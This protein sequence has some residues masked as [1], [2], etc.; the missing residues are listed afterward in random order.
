M[1]IIIFFKKRMAVCKLYSWWENEVISSDD[2]VIAEVRMCVGLNSKM[3][4]QISPRTPVNY[5]AV[6]F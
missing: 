1:T 4:M 2:Q 3:I 6:H 5:V